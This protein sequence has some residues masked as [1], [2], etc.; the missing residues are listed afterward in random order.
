M[1]R[2][3]FAAPHMSLT[4]HRVGSL[5]RTDS[6]ASLISKLVKHFQ[7]IHRFSVDVTRGLVL[8]FEIGTKAVQS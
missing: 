7:A 6:V 5:R 1:S 2:A 4:A 8:L 3:Q